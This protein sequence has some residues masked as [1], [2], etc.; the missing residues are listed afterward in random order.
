[1]PNVIAS[2][3]TVS[4]GTL[5][6]NNFLIGVDSTV[7]YGPTASTGFWNGVVP[8][9]SGYTVYAQKSSQGPS[10]RSAAN[11]SEL[12]TI[13][14][15]YG[16]TNITTV[17]DALNYFNGQ[18]NFL[19]TNIDYPSINTTG[20]ILYLDA[21]YTP[22]YPRTGTTWNDIGGKTNNATL[23]SDPTYS[24]TAGGCI[25]FNGS[26]LAPV[27]SS[28]LNVTYTGKTITVVGRSSAS[29]WTSGVAQYRAMFGST[30][31]RNWN[32]YVLHDASN[33]YSLHFSAG[34]FGTIS[35]TSNLLAPG[36]WFVVSMVNDS[37]GNCSFYVNGSLLSTHTGVTLT[38]YGAS[39]EAVARAD[40]SWLGDIAIVQLSAVALTSSQVIANQNA[41]KTRFGL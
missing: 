22:S 23:T 36:N 35:S 32:F 34:G 13:A 7:I 38:Q 1:M 21:G 20:T 2:G 29:G 18:S 25:T 17:T 14:R 9:T 24:S 6:R 26:N 10:I 28:L 16:G 19:V 11:D 31:T 33:N 3:T 5:K 39:D 41:L 30:S 4:N 37:S 27:T 40:N 8:P 15:Q 12:I